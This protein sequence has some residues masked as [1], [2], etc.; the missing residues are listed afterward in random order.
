MT[1]TID[2]LPASI[3]WSDTRFNR[4]WVLPKIWTQETSRPFAIYWSDSLQHGILSPSPS[5][6]EL[7][8]FYDISTYAEYLSGTQKKQ[9]SRKSVVD[10]LFIKLAYLADHSVSDPVPSI[11]GL[12]GKQ[13]LSVCDIGCGS[14]AFLDRMKA[15]GAELVGIDPSAVSGSA[16]TA[17][18]IEFYSGTG[19]NLPTAVES[20][21]FD[22]VTMFQSLEHCSDPERTLSNAARLLKANGLFVVDVPNIDC[23]GFRLYRHAWSHTDAGRHLHFFTPKS[24]MSF[25]KRARLEPIKVEYCGFT[26]QFERDWVDAMAEVWDKMFSGRPSINNVPPRP[27][28]SM[29]RAY[30][31]LAIFAPNRLKYDIVRLYA[32]PAEP[33]LSSAAE[34]RLP[35]K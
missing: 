5:V 6:T 24:L 32:R 29:S 16:V 11:T 3:L 22:V 23:L 20:R 13:S 30:L 19:E 12:C 8:A 21:R 31:P 34:L 15:L 17:R 26:Q 25:C 27:S 4:R 7:A 10:R 2:S 1:T 14:G 9:I 35:R 28:V 33:R 18:G